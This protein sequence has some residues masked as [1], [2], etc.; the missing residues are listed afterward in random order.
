MIKIQSISDII[1]NSSSEVFLMSLTNAKR[2]EAKYADV[3]NGCITH[4]KL[5]FENPD[6]YPEGTILKKLGVYIPGLDSP[7]WETCELMLRTWIINNPDWINEHLPDDPVILDIEDH[8][9]YDDWEE[10][11]NDAMNVSVWSESRH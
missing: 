1:T 4:R 6:I 8:F 3:D 9:D 5:D 7:D 10:A 11:S 2:I